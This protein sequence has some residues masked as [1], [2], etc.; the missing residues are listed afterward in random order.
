VLGFYVSGH[1]L[2]KYRDELSLFANSNNAG[3]TDFPDGREVTIGGIVTAVK[4]MFDKKGNMMAF[5]TIEDFSGAVELIIFS[6]C[7]EKGKDYILIDQM[8]LIM[9]RVSTREGEA[10]KVIASEVLPLEKITERFNCQLVI[11]IDDDCSEKIIDKAL[12]ELGKNTGNVPVLLAAR[13]NGSI[14]YIK[15]KK[16]S[17]N[18]DFKLL[19]QLKELL[20]HSSAYL[21]PVSKKEIYS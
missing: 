20:G 13:E 3:L 4:T 7:Y 21:R 17:V 14:V 5:T 6:D 10:P 18:M 2:D 15:S 9:G 19:N 12:A 1:P 11:K 8:I 16:F